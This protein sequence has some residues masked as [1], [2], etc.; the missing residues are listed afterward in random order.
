MQGSSSNYELRDGRDRG[1]TLVWFFGTL[2][3]SWRPKPSIRLDTDQWARVGPV[4]T[5]ELEWERSWFD[6]IRFDCCGLVVIT[7]I[8]Q[9]ASCRQ[10]TVNEIQR[11]RKQLTAAKKARVPCQKCALYEQIGSKFDRINNFGRAP[12][13]RIIPSISNRINQI[14]QI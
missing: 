4:W 5:F 7:M 9:E 14:T 3:P 10:Q 13:G 11:R 6:L 12:S 8:C 2:R 1:P